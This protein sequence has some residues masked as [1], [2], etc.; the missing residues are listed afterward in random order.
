MSRELLQTK[1]NQQVNIKSVLGWEKG[2]QK[3]D[4]RMRFEEEVRF[5]K[6]PPASVH[7]LTFIYMLFIHVI[8][9]WL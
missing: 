2:V 4:E 9:L 3:V 8:V 6:E 1:E 5:R 7:A